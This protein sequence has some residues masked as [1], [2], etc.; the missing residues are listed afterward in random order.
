M[1][2]RLLTHVISLPQQAG[3]LKINPDAVT[4]PPVLTLMA[5]SLGDNPLWSLCSRD[6]DTLTCVP[7]PHETLPSIEREREGERQSKNDW[8]YSRCCVNYKLF[9]MKG[10]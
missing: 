10:R 7:R 4:P 9:L 8:D 5:L 2:L 3:L 6:S 1:S